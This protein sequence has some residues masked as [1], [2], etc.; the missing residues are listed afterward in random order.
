MYII[1]S[2]RQAYMY[3]NQFKHAHVM[4]CKAALA[5]VPGMV[6]CSEYSSDQTPRAHLHQNA[7]TDWID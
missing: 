3:I 4:C 7:G 2:G 5:Q 1:I 6:S